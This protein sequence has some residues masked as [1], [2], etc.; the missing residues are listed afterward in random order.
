MVDMLYLSVESTACCEGGGR[1]IGRGVLPG[2]H[3]TGIQ[4]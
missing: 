1:R 4:R 3:E 2:L